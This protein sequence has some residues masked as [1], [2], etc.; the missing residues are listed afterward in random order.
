ML[1]CNASSQ[2]AEWERKVV[3]DN[4]GLY[5]SMK[6]DTFGNAHVAY[7]DGPRHTL[8]YSFWDH[9]LD[10]WFTTAV[11]ESG[12]FCS[13]ALD[14]KQRPHISYVDWGGG[15]LKHAYWDGITWRRETIQIQAKEISFYTSIA[16][17]KNDHPTISFYE[18]FAADGSNLL[19][20]RTVTWN[21]QYWEVRTI[22]SDAGSGKFNSIAIDSKGYPHIAYGNVKYENGSLRYAHWNGTSWEL[23]IVEGAGKPGTIC[24]SVSLV[25]DQD[26]QPHITYTNVSER[27]VKYAWKKDGKWVTEVVDSLFREG[28]PDRNGIALD[29][30]GNPYISYFDA[31]EGL[32]KLAHRVD[33]KWVSEIVDQGYV[34]FNNSLRIDHGVVWITYADASD[35]ALRY[36]RREIDDVGSIDRNAVSAVAK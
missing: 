24:W 4:G 6:F 15:R 31:G 22:D 34:G 30:H 9:K 14:S 26:D 13:L 5:S 23:E 16:L 12:G 28:Y 36:A 25:V 20:L 27:L 2:G 35:N 18:Y 1:L 8:K 3:D 10:K 7:Y 17:D 11:D 29:D 33:G 32:L 19:R 21:G